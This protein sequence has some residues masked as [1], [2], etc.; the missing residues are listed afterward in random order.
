LA[1]CIINEQAYNIDGILFDK[2]GTLLDFGSLWIEWAQQFIKQIRKKTKGK[3]EINNHIF[4]ESIGFYWDKKSWDPRGP[5]AMGSIDQLVTI[6]SF[7][8]YKMGISWDEAI[9]T[10]K[11]CEEEVD[12]HIDWDQLVTPVNGLK[13]FLRQAKQASIK[14][15]VVTS[16]NYQLAKKHLN[17]LGVDEFFEIVIGH[18]QVRR[19]KPFPDMVNL[20]CEQL[21]LSPG[22]TLI[23]GDSNGDMILG[24]NS[25]L[26]AGIGIVSHKVGI[27]E[28]LKDADQI[29]ENYHLIKII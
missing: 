9:H 26:L 8:L 1:I 3:C 19:G 6:L 24:K 2:D 4:A 15:G 25:R 7:N 29:I 13:E 23:I 27:R 17:I 12:K 11:D 22:K 18:D 20:A 10:V 21:S 16:D 5:L 14:M 28:H